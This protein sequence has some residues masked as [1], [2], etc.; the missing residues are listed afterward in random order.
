MTRQLL[1]ALLICGLF[2]LAV[3]G[4][5]TQAARGKRPALVA[6]RAPAFSS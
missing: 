2:A 3:L 1:I 6:R 4:A 5:I